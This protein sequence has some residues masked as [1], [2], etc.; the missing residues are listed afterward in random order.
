MKPNNGRY[1]LAPF[2]L[3]NII[4]SRLF[5]LLVGWRFASFGPRCNILFPEGIEGAKNIHLGSDVLVGAHS[6]LAVRTILNGQ[7]S[8]L[9]IS[10]GVRLGRF[11][12]I[13]ATG[14]IVIGKR[15]MTAN[16][17]Y[18]ADNSHRFDDPTIPIFE[19]PVEQLSSVEIGEG[20]WIGHGACVIGAKIGRNCVIGAM[21]VVRT[22]IPDFCVAVGAPARIVKRYDSS[23]K[24]WRRTRTDGAFLID[25][26]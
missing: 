9:I 20:S 21:S 11:N 8:E 25:H 17:V 18:I 4:Y 12:H 13:Y 10:D 24:C 22:D 1:L 16:N 5:R 14:R 15:V 19:Q 26:V 3:R 23:V 6:Y 7:R 2:R